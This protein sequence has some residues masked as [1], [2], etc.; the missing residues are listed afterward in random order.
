MCSESAFDRN[1]GGPDSNVYTG[2]SYGTYYA[3]D[4][5][6]LDSIANFG[7]ID[8][9]AVRFLGD[10]ASGLSFINTMTNAPDHNYF[11]PGTGVSGTFV[12]GVSAFLNCN[13]LLGVAYR[14]PFVHSRHSHGG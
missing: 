14:Q 10:A 5:L 12:H 4:S 2:G 9:I 7:G 3:A 11:M 8:C 1:G 13:A 6:Y